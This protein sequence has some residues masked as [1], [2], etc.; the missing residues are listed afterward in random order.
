MLSWNML[1][2]QRSFSLL[3]VACVL[4]ACASLAHPK[5]RIIDIDQATDQ[6]Y[7]NEPRLMVLPASLKA[8]PDQLV[9]AGY[10]DNIELDAARGEAES[11]QLLFYSG[12]EAA[13]L[14]CQTEPLTGP[15]GAA[16]APIVETAAY[17]FVNKPSFVGF[18]QRAYYPD[19]LLP[20][21]AVQV[22]PKSNR[23]FFI[24]VR[25][26]A[27]APAGLYAGSIHVKD[28]GKKD[29]TVPIKLKVYDVDLPKTSFLKSSV[30]FRKENFNDKRYYNGAWTKERD[31][32]LP[33]L[34]LDYRFTSRVDLPLDSVFSVD[35]AGTTSADWE[36]FDN[37]VSAWLDLGI[38]CFELKLGIPWT[39]P[40]DKIAERY[41][42]MLRLI[43]EHLGQS[44]LADR[45][46]FYFFDEPGFWELQAIRERFDAI[47]A[48][49]PSIPHIL[50]YGFTTA[51]QRSLLE[52]VGIW[53]PNIDQY[54]RAF[55]QKRRSEGNEV[56][57]YVCVNNAFLRFP[58]NFRI[59]WYGTAHRALGWWLKKYHVD[60]FLYWAVDLWREDPWRNPATFPWTNGDGMLFYPALDKASAPYPSIRAHLFRDAIEDFDLLTLL[61]LDYPEE[62]KRS[63]EI[64]SLLNAESLIPARDSFSIDDELYQIQ[65]RRL[66]ELLEAR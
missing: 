64:V 1:R 66:L 34:G 28:K 60:G 59:D 36:L 38:T 49:A 55:A 7:A 16:I 2:V 6:D 8:R 62:A 61:E 23:A 19:P 58:D 50:T 3:A 40:A 52:Q 20:S 15:N 25:V 63:P 57:V 4:S 13:D 22:P 30:N 21:A 12:D 53:V 45:F 10:K 56:W 33:F 65:H 26:P 42:D 43:E 46:Y 47:K 32:T 44:D 29:W 41:G 35:K 17:I 31:D 48:L 24:T 37:T 27:E 54:D 9:R 39:L 5:Y 51:G 11:I 18:R 14:I